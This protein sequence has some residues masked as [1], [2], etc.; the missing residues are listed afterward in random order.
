MV[1]DLIHGEESEEANM[2]GH[3]P[4]HT[5]TS[6]EKAN[7]SNFQA[8]LCPIMMEP[9]QDPVVAKD[10][11]TYSSA[12][13]KQWLSANGTSPT[14]REY[15][16]NDAVFRNFALQTAMEEVAL[17]S[18]E[19]EKKLTKCNE[20]EKTMT[21]AMD[22]M[23]TMLVSETAKVNKLENK[24]QMM[25]KERDN[26][27]MEK[28]T[29]VK[30]YEMKL[31]NKEMEV[32]ENQTKLDMEHAGWTKAVKE[33]SKL[34]KEKNAIKKKLASTMKA[35]KNKREKMD[36]IV[37]MLQDEH[38]NDMTTTNPKASKKAKH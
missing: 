18:T 9:L 27:K 24:I 16:A 21:M 30:E 35:L 25:T 13:L 32:K 3:Q 26:S 5:W 34:L 38:E 36:E 14:T 29:L 31:D 20:K 22:L 17:Y 19:T 4:R 10:G 8:F 12:A 11:Q 7:L 6:E 33:N 37:R 23:R 15:I 1:I 2:T 28:A